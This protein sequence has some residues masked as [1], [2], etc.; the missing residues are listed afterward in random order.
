MAVFF[1]FIAAC[2][3][4]FTL[5]LPPG[6]CSNLFDVQPMPLVVPVGASLRLH[7][8]I[9]TR[10]LERYSHCPA[11]TLD[12]F[13]WI[14]EDPGIAELEKQGERVTVMGLAVGRTWIRVQYGD[15]LDPSQVSLGRD[16]AKIRKRVPLDVVEP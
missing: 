13:D 6:N 9:D 7:M 12:G 1:G 14:V 4:T 15:Y 3:D 11:M 2:E 10:R 8:R 16:S 5:D